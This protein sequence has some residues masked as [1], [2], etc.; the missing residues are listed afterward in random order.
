MTG[1]LKALSPR[2]RDHVG[3]AMSLRANALKSTEP[4]VRLELLLESHDRLEDAR[5]Q[6]LMESLGRG[7]P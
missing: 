4:T 5:M 3:A 6:L 7:T 2:V 1:P